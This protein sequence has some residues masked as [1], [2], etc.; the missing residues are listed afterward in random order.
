MT[1]K[2]DTGIEFERHVTEVIGQLDVEITLE[3][4][5]ELEDSS[6]SGRIASW[7]TEPSSYSMP[8]PDMLVSYGGKGV[9][10]EAK[11]YPVLLGPV[12]QMKH[13]ADYYDMPAIICVPDDAYQEIPTSVQEWAELNEIVLSPIGEIGDNLKMM[14]QE[15][16]G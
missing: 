6:W 8:R 9:L 2:Q 3:P 15:Y 13:F 12:I 5:R 11:S 14:L 4:L 1:T 16:N 7:F 10:V